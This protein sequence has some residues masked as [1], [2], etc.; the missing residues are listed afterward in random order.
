MPESLPISESF[1]KIQAWFSQH[2]LDVAFNPPVT[3]PALENFT[4]KTGLPLPADLQKILLLA[5]GEPRKSAGMIGNWRLMSICEIQA[6]WGLL[7]RIAEK[8]GFADLEPASSPYIHKAWWHPSWIPLVASDTGH[9]F[10]IAT[11]PPEIERSGQVL[12]Y[13]HGMPERP[14]I[15][16]SLHAWMASI[17]RDLYEGIYT[18]D[19]DQGF[20]NEAFMWSALEQKHLFDGD[21]GKWIA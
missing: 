20:N 11:N 6:A 18:Y 16:G 4:Q 5:D 1:E 19:P 7:T 9:Y 21:K 13:L 12:L 8:G 2:A 3:R 17:Q 10:C 15:A 14:L